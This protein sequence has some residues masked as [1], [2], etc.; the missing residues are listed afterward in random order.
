MTSMHSKV[1]AVAVD[2]QAPDALAHSLVVFL[3]F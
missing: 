3:A 2:L 1:L